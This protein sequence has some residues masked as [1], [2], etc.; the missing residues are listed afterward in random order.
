MT[1]FKQR[2]SWLVLGWVTHSSAVSFYFKV[3]I[4]QVMLR[5]SYIFTH[6]V[7]NYAGDFSQRGE[8]YIIIT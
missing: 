6:R 7:Y 5:N 3:M 1:E 2:L 8:M 4:A